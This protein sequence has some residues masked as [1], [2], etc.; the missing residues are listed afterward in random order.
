ME[1][2][3]SAS[4][5][6]EKFT[7]CTVVFLKARCNLVCIL[8]SHFVLKKILFLDCK[9]T[10]LEVLRDAIISGLWDRWYGWEGKFIFHF[11][12]LTL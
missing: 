7:K 11:M 1:L 3:K 5:D 9:Y 8:K 10:F 4:I 6:K 12:P 2:G